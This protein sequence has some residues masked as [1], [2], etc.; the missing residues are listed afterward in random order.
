VST[1]K[2]RRLDLDKRMAQRE[3]LAL[4]DQVPA[5]L[6]TA[7]ER[8]AALERIAEG[9]RPR[10]RAILLGLV[11]LRRAGTKFSKALPSEPALAAYA[12][13]FKHRVA[14]LTQA[15]QLAAQVARDLADPSGNPAHPPG[16]PGLPT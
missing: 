1:I 4:L 13:Q 7:E 8:D 3:A 12:E 16:G 5:S 9:A 15:T 11:R 6:R 10:V 2:Q 14:S